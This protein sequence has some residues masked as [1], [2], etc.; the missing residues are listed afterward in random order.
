MNEKF[1]GLQVRMAPCMQGRGSGAT[2]TR[3]TMAMAMALLRWRAIRLEF[4]I[5][6]SD[7]PNLTKQ[8]REAAILLASLVILVSLLSG[9]LKLHFLHESTV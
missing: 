7:H 9:F 5:R 8:A 1:A 4:D 3:T 6:G 2:A